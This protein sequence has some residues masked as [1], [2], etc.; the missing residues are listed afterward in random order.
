MEYDGPDGRVYG[1]DE[2]VGRAFLVSDDEVTNDQL[3]AVLD[4]TIDLD[5]TAVVS[6]SLD[7]EGAGGLAKIVTDEPEQVVVSAV[8]Q[9]RNLLVLADTYFPGWKASIDGEQVEIVRVNHLLR[10][11]VVPTGAH[12]VEFT[13]APLSWRIAWIVSLLTALGLAGAAWRRR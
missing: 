13:Y 8:S 2:A 5:R 3:T 12:T 1:N 7:L 4:P 9:G 11:V 6:E 10:G